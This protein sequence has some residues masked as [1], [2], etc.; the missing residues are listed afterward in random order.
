MYA[1][2]ATATVSYIK[3]VELLIQEVP[4]LLMFVNDYTCGFDYHWGHS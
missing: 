4:H 2:I 3:W 1:F